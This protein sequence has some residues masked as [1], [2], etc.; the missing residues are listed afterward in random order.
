MSKTV[1]TSETETKVTFT[2]PIKPKVTFAE[3]PEKS[4]FSTIDFN[5]I[6]DNNIEINK[7]ICMVCKNVSYED[8]QFII[9]QNKDFFNGKI[10]TYFYQYRHYEAEF[11]ND[12]QRGDFY[13]EFTSAKHNPCVI[14]KDAIKDFSQSADGGYTKLYKKQHKDDFTLK[15]NGKRY[16]NPFIYYTYNEGANNEIS[17]PD[18]E[19]GHWLVRTFLSPSAHDFALRGALNKCNMGVIDKIY[20]SH[21]FP[22][23]KNV[24]ESNK[25]MKDDLLNDYT[26]EPISE[27]TITYSAILKK[28][29]IVDE[30]QI[31]VDEEKPIV[32]KEKSNLCVQKDYVVIEKPIVNNE[33]IPIISKETPID[34]DL[35][36]KKV[37]CIQYQTSIFDCSKI[38]N[39]C[40]ITIKN[41]KIVI[42]GLQSDVEM[43]ESNI[44]LIEKLFEI[45][46]DDIDDEEDIAD[47]DSEYAPTDDEN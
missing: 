44:E 46:N 36:T 16:S 31:V 23:K 25:N 19:K 4:V 47:D 43:V 37:S 39:N 7:K 18:G 30:K 34:S 13:I 45:K 5:P 6:Y 41:G 17:N 11:V 15:I 21:K 9:E 14:N 27:K 38:P 33:V 10:S 12:E 28:N 24:D 42:T 2:E 8:F 26:N 29:D 22:S 35:T 32:K 20:T 1:K 40:S 3:A